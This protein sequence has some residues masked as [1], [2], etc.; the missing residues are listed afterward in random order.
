MDKTPTPLFTNLNISLF[1]DEIFADDNSSSLT[2]PTASLD[3]SPS[4]MEHVDSSSVILSS[5]SFSPPIP[6]RRISRVSQ[7]SVLLQDY[8]CNS[9]IVTYEPYTYREASSTPLW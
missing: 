5:S 6:L 3:E 7:P 8:F 4:L 1:P 9:T 2:Q